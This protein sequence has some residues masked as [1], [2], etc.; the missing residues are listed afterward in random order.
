MTTTDRGDAPQ[1]SGQSLT[2]SRTVSSHGPDYISMRVK[3]AGD[4]GQFVDVEIT[5]EDFAL[6]LTG[7][8]E[9]PCKATLRQRS[10]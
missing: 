5:P 9:T 8:S 4:A 7:R 2:I 10:R 1:V 3:L 6:A